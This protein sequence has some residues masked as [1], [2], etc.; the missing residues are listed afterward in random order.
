MRLFIC[1]ALLTVTA[2]ANAQEINRML[3]SVKNSPKLSEYYSPVP[4][5]LPPE[6]Q[7]QK[8]PVM[9]SYYSMAKTCLNGPVSANLK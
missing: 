9:P 4:P 3:D 7:R 2:T 5:W 1:A 6:K 8:R